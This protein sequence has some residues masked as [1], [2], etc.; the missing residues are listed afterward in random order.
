MTPSE[1]LR[2]A[3]ELLAKGWSEPFALDEF[4]HIAVNG[5]VPVSWSVFDALE[6]AAAG[7]I[8]AWLV[9]EEKLLEFVRPRSGRTAEEYLRKRA[10]L[11]VG[12]V[13]LSHWLESVKTQAEVLT[14]FQ[15]AIFRA[16]Q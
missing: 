4:G 13:T 14:L 9:A 16:Q 15:R 1:V 5:A 12:S 10:G 11:S 2:G 3:R 7:D 6:H 8:D